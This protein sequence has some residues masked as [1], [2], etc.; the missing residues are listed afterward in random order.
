MQIALN[1]TTFYPDRQ[2]EV[3]L[4]VKDGLGRSVPNAKLTFFAVDD[5]VLALTG[6]Q[7]PDPYNT[8]FGEIPLNVQMGMT[9]D[10]L[11]A[12][13]PQDLQFTNK[14]YLIGGGG[15]EG[16]GIKVRTN[17][18]GTACWLPSLHTDATGQV[19][20]KFTAPDAI[21]RYRLVAV[22]AAGNNQF[23]SAESAIT[24]QKP[25]LIIPSMAQYAR[26]GDKLGARAVIRNDSGHQ[27]NV[28]VS[29]KLDGRFSSAK[30]TEVTL[31]L[32]NGSAQTV[33]F[34]LVAGSPGSSHWQWVAQ[35]QDHSDGVA[36]DI[37]IG[38]AG[39]T[40]REGYL[41]DLHEK[42]Q[43]LFAGVNP[44]LLEGRRVVYVT[45]ANTRLTSLQ[46]AVAAPRAYPYSCSGQV[47]ARLVPWLVGGRLNSARRRSFA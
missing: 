24:I 31:T 13:D 34:P 12:E 17:F 8:F 29:L 41:S 22:A 38:P 43:D 3:K 23:G 16:P 35:A 6:Y 15:N 11:L 28:R 7:R 40:L 44:Q 2:F 20:A 37:V 10:S 26:S 47:T 27:E 18:P 46:E 9:L 42:Q 33:D 21:T 25:L 32:E 19:T 14:G 5:G 4:E 36:A 39:T 1:Q 30:P 45:L